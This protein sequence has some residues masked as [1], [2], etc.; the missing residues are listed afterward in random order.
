[1]TEQLPD[2][3]PDAPALE[4][5]VQGTYDLARRGSARIVDRGYRRYTGPRRGT[6][7]AVRSL[8]VQTLQ[9]ILGIRRPEKRAA[10]A[11]DTCAVL[12]DDRLEGSHILL[13]LPA[14]EM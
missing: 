4:S 5:Q 7:G 1:M 3:R 2:I 10:D 13:T 11:Q 14:R 8:I 9:R 6:S 12:L